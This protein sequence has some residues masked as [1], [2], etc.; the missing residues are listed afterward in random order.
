MRRLTLALAAIGLSTGA[1]AALQAADEPDLITV[2]QLV[3]T[4]TVALT[5][6]YYLQPSTSGSDLDFASRNSTFV[7]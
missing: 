1:F 7:Q 2:P 4:W 3:S 6:G 5:G